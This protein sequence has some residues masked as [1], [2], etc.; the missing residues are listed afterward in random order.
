M[1]EKTDYTNLGL[2]ADTLYY[3]L[4][5]SLNLNAVKLTTTGRKDGKTWSIREEPLGSHTEYVDASAFDS[6]KTGEYEITVS[7]GGQTK[8]ITAIV[9]EAFEREKGDWDHDQIVS[10]A[11]AQAILNAYVRSIS[12]VKAAMNSEQKKAADVNGD[13]SV[14]VADAQLVLNYYVKNT[15]AKTPTTWEQL[16]NPQ[17]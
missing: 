4:G 2:S 9:I 8:T 10:N 12:G 6:S 1:D 7:V 11:D 15:I 3:E 5:E 17:K 13:G 14:D 16:V